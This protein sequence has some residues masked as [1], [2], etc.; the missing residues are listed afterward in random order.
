M[1]QLLFRYPSPVFAKGQLVLLGRWPAWLLP[2]FILMASLV[3]ALLIRRRMPRSVPILRSWRAWALWAMQVVLLAL[4]LTLLWRPAISVAE[5]SSRQNIIAIVV[6]DSRSMAIVDSNGKT[7]EAAALA[8]LNGGLLADLNK[9]FQT[10]IYR[11]DRA[12]T[13][14]KEG[15]QVVPNAA[16]TH[17]GDGLKQLAA[18]TSDLPV[19]AV[20]LLTDGADNAEGVVNPGVDADALQ[21]LRDRRLPVHVIG[22]GKQEPDHDVEIEDVSV[23]VSAVANT[24]AASTVS[25]TQH[26][27]TGQK[28][29]IAIRDG[30][31]ILASREVTL[32]PAGQIQTE[33]FFFGIGEAGAKDLRFSIDPLTGEENA[34]NNAMTRPVLVTSQKRRILYIEGEPRWEYKF[35]RR[36]ED[37]D[38]SVQLVSMLR[39]SENK[40]YRQGISDPAELADGFPSHA[41]DLFGYSGIIIGSV[42][43]DYFTPEQQELLREYVDSRGG[44]I[45]FLGGRSSLS[46]GGWS[47]SKL[48][49]LLPTSLPSERNSFH[50]DPATVTLTETGAD[51]PITRLLEDRSKNAERWTRLTYLADYQNPGSP[52]PGATVLVNMNVHRRTLPLLITQNY[53]HGRTA[54]LATGGTWR[55]QMAEPLGD[56]SHDLF[57]QQL[58]RWLVAESPDPVTASTPARVLSDEGRV[59][60]TAMVRN[61]QFQPA[62]NAHVT[63]H[64]T[65]PDATDATVDLVPS[66]DMPGKYLTT[67]TADSPG[68]YLAEI[69]A[70]S[71]GSS[72]EEIGRDVVLFRREDG[73]AESFHTS[74]NRQLLEQL[75]SD[76]GGRYWNPSQLRNLPRDISYSEAGISVRSTK[77]LWNLPVVF[78]LLLLLPVAEWLL[79]RRWGIV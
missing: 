73:I 56:T 40:I 11:L 14:L 47:S 59:Q 26:G 48:N 29:T 58:L 23:P 76:T 49:E 41:E 55:W 69:T 15:Q 50:R 3:L 7:R 70:D 1:F 6:D 67:W 46:E 17:I 51:S 72:S 8:A 34:A 64:I 54:I 16:A 77:E 12:V 5:L 35:I 9:R 43:A 74:Q 27:Y 52:R 32:A 22:F 63:A 36:A 44:G 61:R 24:R 65:G 25:F 33:P 42:D 78:T 45:L 39:T 30:Q 38:A 21:A 13:P 66:P 71:D 62:A 28:A 79:R 75:A 2:V 53:G 57:W 60:L 68:T 10:R 19:G 20:L 37:E 4:L 31:K 18:E